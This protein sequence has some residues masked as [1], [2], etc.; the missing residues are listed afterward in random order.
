MLLPQE[1]YQ[2]GQCIGKVQ[3]SQ[4]T[5]ES[6]SDAVRGEQGL[7]QGINRS[8]ACIHRNTQNR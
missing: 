1:H 8:I 4:S 6:E 2:K 5:T 3:E 7:E